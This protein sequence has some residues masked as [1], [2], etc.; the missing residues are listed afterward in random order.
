MVYGSEHAPTVY[1]NNQKTIKLNDSFVNGKVKVER[2][3][4]SSSNTI[5]DNQFYAIYVPYLDI[6]IEATSFAEQLEYYQAFL[7]ETGLSFI[8]SGVDYVMSGIHL[9][10][11]ETEQMIR[12]GKW[13]GTSL[14]NEDEIRKGFLKEEAYE[15]EFFAAYDEVKNASVVDINDQAAISLLINFSPVT[16][17]N[18]KASYENGTVKLESL[19]LTV[20][21]TLLFVEGE[22]YTVNLALLS[23]DPHKKDG[24]IHVTA[25]VDVGTSY[26]K[27]DSF[28]VVAPALTFE[29]PALDNGK[30]T[31]VAYVTTLD[32]IRSSQYI[33]IGFDTVTKD[34]VSY[35]AHTVTAEQNDSSEL[36]LTYAPLLDIQSTVTVNEQTLSYQALYDLIA[37][38]V[39]HHGIISKD[40]SLEC[41][42]G[43][44]DLYVAVTHS[45]EMLKIGRYR[46]PYQKENGQSLERGFIIVDVVYEES[47]DHEKKS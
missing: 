39:L 6:R 26:E 18:H 32:G 15:A 25:P 28:S 36:I 11:E 35:G 33:P 27:A 46:L 23:T 22:S 20:S 3:G 41:Y 2:I 9:A 29:L 16:A 42:D 37:T 8:N 45:E 10:I 24:I 14:D 13:N 38:E 21:D 19:T 47:T 12:H 30:Y 44:S 43:E 7:N 4:V 5:I 34:T 31:V 40:A 1:L 17:S